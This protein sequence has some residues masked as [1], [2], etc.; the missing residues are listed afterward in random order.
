MKRLE[1]FFMIRGRK[2][3]FLMGLTV[4]FTLAILV[5]PPQNSVEPIE[6]S[7]LS[8]NVDSPIS[9]VGNG[10][11]TGYSGNGSPGSPYIIENKVIDGLGSSNCIEITDT[12]AYFVI[13]NCVLYNGNYGIDLHNASNGLV[14]NN[15]AY[16]MAYSGFLV[17][18]GASWNTL[19]N[20]TAYNNAERGIW[21]FGPNVNYNIIDDN[22]FINNS[23]GVFLSQGSHHNTIIGNTI[24]NNSAIGILL[25]ISDNVTIVNNIITNSTE[26]I[27]LS[28][29]DNATIFDNVI[30][31]NSEQ[32]IYVY[33]SHDNNITLNSIINNVITGIL[34][35]N[36][37]NNTMTNNALHRNGI[38]VND[39]GGSGNSETGNSYYAPTLTDGTLLPSIGDTSTVFVYSVIYTDVDNRAPTS[40][41]VVIDDV[42]HTMTKLS[43]DDNTY[44]D[45]CIYIYTTTVAVGV[46][47]RYHYEATDYADT[48]RTP[49]T[50]DYL[51]PIVMEVAGGIPGFSV[52]F[53]ILGLLSVI[54]LIFA[55]RRKNLATI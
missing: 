15:I 40:I 53:G 18:Q 26:G 12:D 16:D 4:L 3:F 55:I 50:G 51:G 29:A 41:K 38:A 22:T 36:S 14:I 52:L 17:Y 33:D 42:S 20:N 1:R 54:G 11:F 8:P 2:L 19:R 21:L 35:E 37:E 13:Q 45:G 5:S 6:N 27:F 25:Q 44:S 48:V 49:N 9:I 28:S 46:I 10:G 43:P 30:Q 39:T 23:R 24:H 32:G 47:H 31:D 7:I 34:L